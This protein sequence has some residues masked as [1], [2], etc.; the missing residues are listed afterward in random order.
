MSVY[1][2]EDFDCVCY[3]DEKTNNVV[4][5]FF[6]MPNNDSAQLFTSYVMA[7]LGFEYMP[8]GEDSYSKSIH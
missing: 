5:K 2:A 4:I 8:F 6:G 3:I 1:Y 7:K